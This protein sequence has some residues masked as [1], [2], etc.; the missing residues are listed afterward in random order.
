MQLKQSTLTTLL[1]AKSLFNETKNLISLENKYS[2]TA[3][4]II[5]QDFVEL[6]L[7][8]ALNELEPEDKKSNDS[9][10]FDEL[11]SQL[12]KLGAPIHKLQTI[13]GLNKQ[14]VISKHYGQLSEPLS[15]S[16]YF[17]ES[18][19]FA[20]T[21][22]SYTVGKKLNEIFLTDLLNEGPTKDFVLEAIK[23]SEG[24]LFLEALTSLRKAFYTAYENCYCIY[25]YRKQVNLSTILGFHTFFG[26]KA[27]SHTKNKEWIE[28]NVKF[29]LGYLQ[30]D[31]SQLKTDCLELGVNTV[32]IENFRR[33]TPGVIET[34]SGHWH[35]SYAM[36]YAN[37]EL[38]LENFSY[39]LDVVISFL[40]KKQEFE[41]KRKYYK[42]EKSMPFPPVYYGK[43][44]F[45]RPSQ[46]SDIISFVKDGYFYAVHDILSGFKS[47]EK[48][49]YVHL[50]PQT[51]EVML[52]PPVWGYLLQ[53]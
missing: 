3:G 39:C 48:Y 41:S 45:S 5:L 13:K 37:N 7:L 34:E 32:E 11:L 16:N 27:L 36:H 18:V 31:F 19:I 10:S 52:E 43:P 20:D 17:S 35:I 12:N 15:V 9:K 46:E 30:V 22:L 8:A 51:P 38:T 53:D 28:A 24:S 47:N 49:F 44:V 40:L 23:Y 6:I 50:W 14:R 29:P 4:I 2:S 33:L 25:E 26:S 1:V 21:L 42:L